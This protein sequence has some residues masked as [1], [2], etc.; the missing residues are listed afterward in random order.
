MYRCIFVL[1]AAFL[2]LVPAFAQIAAAEA[3]IPTSPY[4]LAK[5]VTK[6]LDTPEQRASVMGL[7][8][9]ARQNGDLH[10]VGA[11]PFTV[12]VSFT[13]AGNATYTGNGEMEETWVSRRL[14]S[15]T[16]HLAGYSQY[17][18]MN[19]R[20]YD[21]YIGP[22]PM[23]VAMLRSIL[24][25]P[26]SLGQQAQLRISAGD[27]QEKKIMCILVSGGMALADSAP[28]RRWEES[29]YC[30]DTASGL[31]Q[32]YSPAPGIYVVY[33]YAKAILFHA[34]SVPR[35]ITVYEGDS[36]VLQAHVD[37][38]SNATL[39]GNLFKPT[40]SMAS[41]E[42]GPFISFP[43][44]ISAMSQNSPLSNNGMIQPVIVIA[45]VSPD[46]TVT[47]A[48]A[49]PTSDPVLSS[50][51][52]DVARHGSYSFPMRGRKAQTETFINVRFLPAA[53]N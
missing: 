29:E 27:W 26:L 12:K 31:L 40:P 15:W 43:A 49:L 10:T 37:S 38:L 42:S 9:R 25:W 8:D 46:G 21:D 1:L 52:L 48:E 24:Y 2:S 51:A 11:A 35:A 36:P 3:P 20:V 45:E 30:I 5:G 17:R 44:H 50:A 32:T 18:I 47:E 22:I 6:L 4:E 34:R 28:G 41:H 23:R 39:R 14:W 53:K 7:I 16:A 33:D 19:D 13:A